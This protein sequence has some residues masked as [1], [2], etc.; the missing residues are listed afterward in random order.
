MP[1][2]HLRVCEPCNK[3]R[4]APCCKSCRIPPDH[5]RSSWVDN[6]QRGAGEFLRERV[7]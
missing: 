2:K 1:L 5:D 6:L 4:W 3:V 7:Q